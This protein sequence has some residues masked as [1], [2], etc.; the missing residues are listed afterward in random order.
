MYFDELVKKGKINPKNYFGHG[1]MM[2]SQ[3]FNDKLDESLGNTKGKRSKKKQNYKDRR[4]ES[5]AMEK[6]QGRRKYARVKTMDKGNRKKRK[7]PMT[8]A[9]AIRRDG[10][11]W[12]DALKRAVAMMK[13]DA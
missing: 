11:K 13:K 4:D 3:G 2:H 6:K 10:E 7:T 1:G 9:K 8:L 12:Q 5:E